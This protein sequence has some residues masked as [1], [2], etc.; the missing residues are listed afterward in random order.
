MRGENRLPVICD[1]STSRRCYIC[2]RREI[3]FIRQSVGVV[4]Q[5]PGDDRYGETF[6]INDVCGTASI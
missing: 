6:N 3:T 2:P 1:E 5:T 4:S